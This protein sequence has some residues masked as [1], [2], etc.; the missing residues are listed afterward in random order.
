MCFYRYLAIHLK[1]KNG[2]NWEYSEMDTKK[3]FRSYHGKNLIKD[4]KGLSWSKNS[5]NLMISHE[6]H[7]KINIEIYSINKNGEATL[8]R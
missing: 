4:L 8:E 2:K 1:I 7:F 5:D 3:L 6:D